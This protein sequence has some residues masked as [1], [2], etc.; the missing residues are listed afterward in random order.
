MLAPYR[1]VLGTDGAR[2]FASAGVL[3]RLPISTIGLGIVLLIAARTDSYALAG[4][5]S[6][7][8]TLAEGAAAPVLGRAVDRFGQSRVLLPASALFTTLVVALMTSVENDWP[9]AVT[10]VI[11]AVGGVLIPPVGACVRARWA[12][13]LAG[14]PTLHTA[15]ALESVLDEVVFMVGPVLVTLLATQVHELA[16]L[17]V[18]LAISLCGVWWLASLRHTEPPVGGGARPHARAGERLDWRWLVRVVV[19][20]ACLGSLFGATEVVTVAFT[21]EAGHAAMAGVLLATWAFGSLLAGLVVGLVTWRAS[22]LNRYRWGAVGMAAVMLPLPFI[23][24]LW[25]LWVVLFLAGFAIS[26]TLVAVFSLVEES[27]PPGRL[28]EGIT[29]IT[30]GI[31]LGIAPGAAIAGQIID[32]HGAGPGYY[33]P[34]VSGLVAAAI[35]WTTRPPAPPLPSPVTSTPPAPDATPAG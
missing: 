9:H 19:V 22:T 13:V 34:A 6:A 31:G 14:K 12:Y 33:V 15:Y 28:T 26:P 11:A 25:L 29:W 8:F 18:V 24:A 32:A 17:A 35:A 16:G 7:V 23:D 10:F 2:S 5:V 20:A 3:G 30:T 21:D 4:A 1:A 27:V